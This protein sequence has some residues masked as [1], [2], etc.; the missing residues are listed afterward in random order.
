MNAEG[1]TAWRATDAY[2]LPSNEDG[3]CHSSRR[4]VAGEASAADTSSRSR[5]HRRMEN[6]S[7][8]V[9]PVQVRG[10]APMSL[11]AK[12]KADRLFGGMMGHGRY[13]RE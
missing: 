13:A 9:G 8:Y 11:W 1:L 2:Q 6:G 12:G 4:D 3:A 5:G 10:V 7:S